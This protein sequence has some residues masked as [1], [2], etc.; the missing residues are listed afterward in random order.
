M[1][2]NVI[3]LNH[4]ETG[5]R[6]TQKYENIHPLSTSHVLLSSANSLTIYDIVYGTVQ[7]E[8]R[9]PNS[10]ATIVNTT[11]PLCFHAVVT[12]DGQTQVVLITIPETA[13]LLDSIG[14]GQASDDLIKYPPVLVGPNVSIT[15]EEARADVKELFDKLK[16]TADAQDAEAF[17]KHF[18]E[19]RKRYKAHRRRKSKKSTILPPMFVKTLLS[20]IFTK[21]GDGLLM[22]IYPSDT[23]KYLL[24]EGIFSRDLLPG[25]A[26]GLLLVALGN[27]S[28][29]GS[30]V[31]CCPGSRGGG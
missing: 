23:I 2:L 18:T 3:Q 17:D 29:T 27:K 8:L 1:D 21:E 24:D 13:T 11:D 20:L 4:N 6:L 12:A 15:M 19:F 28:T 30:T 16:E 26:T 25:G 7:A 14:K 5:F 31:K 10:F 9:L 22:T